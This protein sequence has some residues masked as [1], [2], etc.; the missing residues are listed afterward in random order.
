VNFS[1][2]TYQLGQHSTAFDGEIEAIRTTLRLLNLHQDK[3]ERAGNFSDSEAA[4]LTAGSTE[5]VISTEPRDCQALIRQLKA[6]H[7]QITLQWIPGHCQIA[8]NEQADV[9]AKNGAKITQ[10]HIR[11]I[12]YRPI[13]LHLKQVFHS[14]YRH[15]LETRLSHKPWKQEIAKIPDW[16]R[17]KAVTEFRLCLGQDCLCTHLHRIGIRPDPYCMLCSLREPMDRNHLGPCTALLIGQS[18]SDT[19]GPGQK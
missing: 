17:R 18:V 1:P 6:N 16:P 3:F 15:E 5:T 12:S 9:L 10:T 2:V 7:K 4:I 11:E 14:A 8:G 13:K 19:G